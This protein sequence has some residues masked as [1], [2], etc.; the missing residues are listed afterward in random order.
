MNLALIT[1]GLV[2]QW[3]ISYRGGLRL[4]NQAFI[5]YIEKYYQF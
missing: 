2:F 5:N 1:R 4:L 3:R